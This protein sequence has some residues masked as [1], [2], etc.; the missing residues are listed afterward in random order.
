[1]NLPYSDVNRRIE[2]LTNLLRGRKV[3]QLELT[4]YDID[5]DIKEI[6][7]WRELGKSKAQQYKGNK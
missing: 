5:I 4:L 7:Y 3:S 2:L 6:E 1:M